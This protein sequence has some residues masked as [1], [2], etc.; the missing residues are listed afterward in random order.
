MKPAAEAGFPVPRAAGSEVVRSV[1]DG[2]CDNLFLDS[3]FFIQYNRKQD[4]ETGLI[5]VS[6]KIRYDTIKKSI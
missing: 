3:A 6:I 4:V 1:L 2:K 5:H